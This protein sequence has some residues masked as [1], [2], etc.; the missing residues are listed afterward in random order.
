MKL[1]KYELRINGCVNEDTA[2]YVDMRSGASYSVIMKSSAAKRTAAE[3]RI[4]GKN[5]GTFSLGAFS[6]AELE[7]PLNENMKFTFYK[8]G[9]DGYVKSE[10]YKISKHDEG[11]VTVTFTPEKESQQPELLSKGVS[12]G[13]AGATG[14]SGQSDQRIG[15]T[16]SFDLD[17]KEAIT[18]NLRLVCRKDDIKPLRSREN[19][20]PVPL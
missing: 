5:V 7:R 8:T 14:L 3:L 4:D 9:S 2:G 15:T 11:L 10:A 1:G 18:I 6:S 12:K 13:C 17:H 19:T 20:V 16:K